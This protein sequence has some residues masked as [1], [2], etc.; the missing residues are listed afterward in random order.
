VFS[1]T[2][3]GGVAVTDELTLSTTGVSGTSYTEWSGKTATSSA[4]YA[5]QSAGG[6]SSIQLRSNNSNSGIIQSKKWRSFPNN[7]VYSGSF[8]GSS[9]SGR[10]T[11]GVYW[12]S[13]AAVNT[14]YNAYSLLFQSD[15]LSPGD[16][17]ASRN[18]GRS[19]RCIAK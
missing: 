6:N 11:G 17:S 3:G 7:F 2:E 12:S 13:S 19:V 18:N 10:N 14:D 1:K 16:G 15:F 4:V 9:I 8:N 5:G